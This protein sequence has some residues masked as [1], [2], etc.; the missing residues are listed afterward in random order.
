MRSLCPECT[1]HKLAL[2]CSVRQEAHS[3]HEGGSDEQDLPGDRAPSLEWQFNTSSQHLQIEKA[4][5]ASVK[6]SLPQFTCLKWKDNDG[7]YTTW[8][9]LVDKP[10]RT[11]MKTCLRRYN[12]KVSIC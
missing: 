8:C 9:S 10:H 5:G 7:N 3:G 4:Q 11:H 1:A 2:F 6:Y 12:L